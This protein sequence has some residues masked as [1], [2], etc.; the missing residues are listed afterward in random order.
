MQQFQKTGAHAETYSIFIVRRS[1]FTD[2]RKTREKANNRSIRGNFT[3]EGMFINKLVDET[4][5]TSM[6]TL[7]AYWS[8]GCNVFI[9]SLKTTPA[10]SLE[11]MIRDIYCLKNHKSS[12]EL[13]KYGVEQA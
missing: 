7:W 5:Y 10:L 3:S 4:I 12:A 11:E 2:R 6:V 1:D 9:N 13:I 8:N